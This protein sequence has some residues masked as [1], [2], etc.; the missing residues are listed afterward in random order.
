MHCAHHIKVHFTGRHGFIYLPIALSM[1]ALLA[2]AG[3]SFA[4]HKHKTVSILVPSI[5]YMV[6]AAHAV[7]I[8]ISSWGNK[9]KEDLLPSSF[10]AFFRHLCA[11]I[12]LVMVGSII[13]LHVSA[14]AV[15][16]TMDYFSSTFFLQSSNQRRSSTAVR[17]WASGQMLFRPIVGVGGLGTIYVLACLTPAALHAPSSHQAI[18]NSTSMSTCLKDFLLLHALAAFLPECL[19]VAFGT[20]MGFMQ[21]MLDGGVGFFSRRKED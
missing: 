20:M 12:P 6:T 11:M 17:H 16:Q 9:Q 3:P 19:G 21:T 7:A 15:F 10:A 1:M 8:I 14:H 13:L 5:L 4:K 2:G 18:C